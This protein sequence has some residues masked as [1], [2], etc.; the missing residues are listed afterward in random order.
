MGA[1]GFRLC[2]AVPSIGLRVGQPTARAI[3][4]PL[5]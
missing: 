2:C 4:A 3:T 5:A 1:P